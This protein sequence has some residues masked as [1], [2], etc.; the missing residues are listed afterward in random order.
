MTKLLKSTPKQDGFKMPGEFAPHSGCWMVWPERTDNWRLGGK[1]AQAVFA[2][3]A[4]AIQESEPVTVA[5]SHDQY[6]NARVMLRPDIRLVEMSSNDSWMRDIGPSFVVNNQGE[7]R[8]VDWEFNSWG[9]LYNGLYFPWD[10][11]DAVA[12]KVAEIEGSDRYRAPIVLE[13]GSIHIDGEGTLITTEE[14]LLS[15]GRNPDLD[16]QQIE[17]TLKDYLGVEKVIWIKRGVYMDETTGHVDNLIHY[18]KPG[19]VA[20]TWTDDQNDPQ[21]EISN[22]AFEFLSKE[23]DAKGRLLEVVKIHQP[24][25]LFL[26]K[27]EAEG[28]DLSES[29]MS[30]EE[31]DRLAGSYCNFYI[32]NSRVVMPLLDERYDQQALDALQK[33]YP[34]KEVVG[35]QAREILLGGGNIHCITQQVPA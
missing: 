27:D 34:D 14:C 6:A 30:R 19:V 23:Q 3:V 15:P 35:I 24:G 7:K 1:P 31:G 20:L 17:Q 16:K 29:G 11:D 2:E 32:G 26:T 4:A 13:G 22:E 10:L 28:V 5:V 8:A 33:I 18:C 25:P 12:S 9:G 21:Y